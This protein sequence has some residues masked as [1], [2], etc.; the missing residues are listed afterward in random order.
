[1][2]AQGAPGRRSHQGLR[3]RR[4]PHEYSWA[5]TARMRCHA[6]NRAGTSPG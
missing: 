4:E 3:G 2:S 1:V 5:A 6:A